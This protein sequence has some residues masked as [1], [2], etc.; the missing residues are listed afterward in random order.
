VYKAHEYLHKNFVILHCVD[1]TKEI[2]LFRIIKIL[3]RGKK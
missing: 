2:I 1:G 3:L